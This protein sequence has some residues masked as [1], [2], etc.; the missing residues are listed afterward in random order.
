MIRKIERTMIIERPID[1]VFAFFANAANL[2]QI[3]PPELSFRI[4]T[5]HPI[6]MRAGTLIDYR[7]QLFSIPFSW[8]SLISVWNPPEEFIDEQLRGPFRLWRHRH[9]FKEIEGTTEMIDSI[10]FRLPFWPF[11]ELFLPVVAHQLARIF[12]YRQEKIKNLLF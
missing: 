5:R 8:Q 1:Q 12:D 6:K 7:L 9:S 2:E 10:E 3:T 11:G 4:L